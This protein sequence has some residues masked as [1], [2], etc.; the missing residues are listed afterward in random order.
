[1]L[2]T[3]P[4]APRVRRLVRRAAH[5]ATALCA[6]AVLP[7][8]ALSIEP[9]PLAPARPV[10]DTYFGTT[11]HD[12]Y[13]WL[14]SVDDPQVQAWMRA[15]SDYARAVLDAIPGRAAL[16][17]RINQLDSATP[18]RVID[19]Q[20]RPGGRMFFQRRGARDNQFKL[21]V[22]DGKGTRLLVDPEKT[23][24]ATGTP[25]AINYMQ[26][27]WN[28]RYVAYG[29][30]AAG[31]ED[32]SLYVVDATN[33]RQV[34]GPVTR[35]AYGAIGWLPDDSG[36]FFNR[37]Q[38]LAP[39]MAPIE[40]FQKTRVMVL[41]LADAR[42]NTSAAPVEPAV[43]ALSFE[44]PGVTINPAQDSPAVFAVHGTALALGLIFHG[45]D[46]ELS[47]YVAPLADAAAGKATWR[48]IIDRS[49]AVTA[50]EVVGDRLFALTH[51]DAPRFRLIETS[52]SAP[53]LAAARTLMPGEPG[54]LT[55]LAHGRDA[56]YVTR[57]DGAASRLFR[58]PL[59][60]KSGAAG[61]PV[62]VK[63]P[64]A[65]SFEIAGTDPRLPGA[66]VT[67]EGWTRAAQIYAVDAKGVRNTNLQ[68]RGRY[69]AL[70]DYVATEVL[71]KSHDGA[72]VPLSI[73]HKRNLKRDGTAP[74][75]LWGYA[76][77]GITEEP[78]FSAWRIAWL[79]QGG[80]FAVANPRGSGAFGQD[81]YKGGFQATKPNTW[82]DFIATA[83]YLVAQKFTSPDRLGIWGGSA[84]GILVGRAMTE[85]PDLFRAV[86]NAVGVNDTV[87]AELTPNG[88]PNI[89]EFGTHTTEAGFRALLAMSTY[90]Q[91]VDG[92]FY[93]AVMFTHGVND[94][95]VDVWQSS[96]A[97]ARLQ[98]AS[99]SI[100]AGRPVLL[101]LD[102]QSGHGIGD[103]REQR[104]AERAD[105][106]GF[107][108]WQFGLARGASPADPVPPPRR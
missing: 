3:L 37:L 76:S 29:L 45:T 70:A 69:D 81:W 74:T 15:Q 102:Y 2:I 72:M 24:R 78:W 14:E 31:S 75:L 8:H 64:L 32:A 77:Y 44:S 4:R 25:H 58:L 52:V 42:A 26:P 65:G 97:A 61:K 11:V 20:R 51:R 41:R 66:L 106:L 90:H 12:P 84:G 108:L 10:S 9:P 13:R 47:A 88:V 73:L 17:A 57:R 85:R 49:D 98:A 87:R 18:A 5:V 104:N 68:P 94:P 7:A 30:S 54:V 99:S 22:R 101:R 53:D 82:R 83:E 91:I 6:V 93:P 60:A 43:T 19:V 1:M 40:K 28:G 92:T 79:E 39:G 33:G 16:L 96:K 46:R 62:E 55:G 67:L 103:T 105:V 23:S 27:S 95:R 71:V 80:V 36:L 21:Y 50:I 35:A 59:D 34:L 38:E 100:A 63:L 86:V 48:K 107:L 89:P 56:L